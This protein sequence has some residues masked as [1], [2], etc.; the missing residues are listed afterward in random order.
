VADH[1]ISVS[2]P[3]FCEALSGYVKLRD[4]FSR[5]KK[6][7]KHSAFVVLYSEDGIENYIKR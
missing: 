1:G 5:E 6:V 3:N 4:V 2:E 7:Q